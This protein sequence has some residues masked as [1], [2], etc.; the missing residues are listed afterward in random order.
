MSESTFIKITNRDIYIEVKGTRNDVNSMR[1][2]IKFLRK[3]VYGTIAGF[4]TTIGILISV[5]QFK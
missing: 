4:T 1:E 5:V 2:E 3:L